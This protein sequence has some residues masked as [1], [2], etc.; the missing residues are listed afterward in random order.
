MPATEKFSR[1]LKTLHV[2]FAFSCLALLVAT[3]WMMADDHAGEWREYQKKNF[4]LTAL[5]RKATLE[6]AQSGRDAQRDADLKADKESAEEELASAQ[7]DIDSI[8]EEIGIFAQ[9]EDLKKR[10]LRELNAGRD[11][12]RANY[13]LGVRDALEEDQL[14]AL[15]KN[16][17]EKQALVDET[18]FALQ[19]DTT[20]LAAKQNQLA[21]RTG[22]R[23]RW[24][25]EIAAI[26]REL[27][28]LQAALDTI[29]PTGF[30]GF[31]RTI[32]EW[33]ILDG[34]NSHLTPKQDW[35]PKL[36][37][38]LGM[39][40]TARFDRC[41]TCH[42][43]IDLTEAGGVPAFPPGH[44]EGDDLEKWVEANEFPQP[45]STHPNTELY[46]TASSPHPV[47]TFGCTICHDGNGSGTSVQN[48]EH[49]PN[50]PHTAAEWAE[51]HHW[52][53]N[54]FWEYPMQP[55]RFV[56]S[57][58]IKCHHNVTELG[59]H[60]KF[61]A[62]AP[63]AFKG[64]QLIKKYGCFGC[65]E[66][67]GYDAGKPIGPD[68]RL[69]PQNA[70]QA[71][72]VA[73]DARQVAGSMR[74][75]GPALTSVGQKTTKG[76][77]QRWTELP[78]A[79]RPSTRMP[80]FFNL[81]N[82]QD[83]YAKAMQPAEL[84]AISQYLMGKSSDAELLAP[85]EGYVPDAAEGKKWFNQ[86][87]C[88]NCHQH[89][90]AGDF[91]PNFGP[92]LSRVHEKIRREPGSAQFS[93]WLYTW[94]RDPERHHPRTK[95]PNLFLDS[96]KFKPTGENAVE[97][98][99]DPAADIV[100]FLL[101]QGDPGEFSEIER[102]PYLG[103]EADDDFTQDEAKSLNLE[104]PTGVRVVSIVPISPAARATDADG[105]N[106]IEPGDVILKIGD[107]PVDSATSLAAAVEALKVGT[108]VTLSVHR[109]R[110]SISLTV[111]LDEPAND[112]ARLFLSKTLTKADVNE[113]LTRGSYSLNGSSI[114]GDEIELAYT[115][116]SLIAKTTRTV[117]SVD[118]D[119]SDSFTTRLAE[120]DQQQGHDSLLANSV[121]Y[122]TTGRN[123]GQISVVKTVDEVSG[124]IQIQAALSR[125]IRKGD[126]FYLNPHQVSVKLDEADPELGA[127]PQWVWQTGVN[128]NSVL[129]V[130]VM[131]ADGTLGVGGQRVSVSGSVEGAADGKVIDIKVNE[132]T[133]SATVI[134]T[135][136]DSTR[137]WFPLGGLALGDEIQ[138]GDKLLTVSAVDQLR[139]PARAPA[140]GDT[141]VISGVI[142]DNMKLNYV[143]RRTI[144]RY[145][146]YAC[147]TIPGFGESR[148]IGTTLQ[149]WGRKDTSK[150]AT[151]HIAE[152]L[153]HHGEGAD[154]HGSTQERAHEAVAKAKA[155]GL[156]AGEFT[157]EED[158]DRELS[159]AF[160][161]ESLLHHGRA[162]FLWQKLRQPRSYDFKKIETK[163]YDERL[164]MPKF[165][166]TD[167]E[168]EAISTFVLGLVAEPPA[169]EYLYR[170]SGP[171]GDRIKGEELLDKYNCTGCHM[172]DMPKIQ[173]GASFD[174]LLTSSLSA[175]E[176][177]PGHDLMLRMRPPVEAVTG[178]K[179]AS[180][181]RLANWLSEYADDPANHTEVLKQQITDLQKAGIGVRALKEAAAL[182]ADDGPTDLKGDAKTKY[183]QF[184]ASN[185]AALSKVIG[186]DV[187]EFQG[188]MM[189]P[190]D[191]E[192]YPE[193]QEYGYQLWNTLKLK[194][195]QDGKSVSAEMWPSTN[196]S[197][198]SP[199]LVNAKPARGGRYA[200]WLVEHLTDTGVSE[201]RGNAWQRV[202]P[203]LYQEGLKVQTPWL[204]NFLKNPVP[205]RHFTVLRMPKFNI[206]DDEA[207][208]LANYFAAYDDV[209]YP[210]QD[211]PE[212]DAP[213]EAMMNQMLDE[214]L[215]D[216]QNYLGEAWKVLNG[217][218]CIGCHSV[219]GRQFVKSTDPKQ[220][221]GPDLKY[222][223]DRLR[224]DWVQLWLYKPQWITPYTAMPAPFPKGNDGIGGGYHGILNGESDLQ[225]RALRDAL[226]NYH[227]L[228][229]RHGETIFKPAEP[230]AG[231]NVAP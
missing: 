95:M 155:G 160:F 13:D 195:Q 106:A 20:Q 125:P 46:A 90:A 45:Y 136:D 231:G 223:A 227:K 191:L 63:K 100:A 216:G 61:G 185:K 135:S 15:F 86:R 91:K 199:D 215:D 158:Q 33:A 179:H 214:K 127:D 115:A 157:S 43:N 64:Y 201:N 109:Q 85:A 83:H 25:A 167:D 4:K 29:A 114:K 144:S 65:H 175:T 94:I 206:S 8:N 204:F 156:K 84:L 12:A 131:G 119:S 133:M 202:P 151:E 60:P 145:G 172:I 169:E 31:K 228:M 107:T 108:E 57:S 205:L 54:H 36:H 123:V 23:D 32:M 3:F 88:T 137:L 66:I 73:E 79:F 152:Y 27:S 87:G 165:P 187:V 9:S 10:K 171:A 143:G 7:S 30:D 213:Y 42:Q 130:A 197:F 1:N 101:S 177:A 34:F 113:T 82:Q 51:H 200:E 53:S 194:M 80:Q 141:L 124:S 168:I 166:F 178:E 176:H 75:V 224:T 121:I 110:A 192:E 183:E 56:E 68:I 105:A 120:S 188:L 154:N 217:P 24:K 222:V 148:P 5:K 72:A 52:H 58:C 71:K 162:G 142:T 35:L 129:D 89:K 103:V 22:D 122:W 21:Q 47:E 19:E 163:G 111:K 170:P 104:S 146:C 28:Q 164:R 126:G 207:Q 230:A 70:A 44:P 190:P 41:R 78:K 161:Y 69:E 153:H 55:S 211:V 193:D 128:Q 67:H 229:E 59:V 50:N 189:F 18:K 182:V 62:S 203:P 226:M 40:K 93:K 219:A 14:A 132:H 2:V 173:F 39:A 212:R 77:V 186:K 118:G 74:K 92:D 149:D 138:I 99:I 17:K 16:F 98:T 150:L 116:T 134:D 140:E 11:V 174:D 208:A 96:Y 225:T 209:P 81:T 6:A 196:V 38:T 184:Y 218:R 180:I 220:I 48:A 76:F 112:L 139:F 26:D 102:K 210:Y 221:Q 198:A 97:K 117:V 181:Y 49:T 159:T 37:I 147:H